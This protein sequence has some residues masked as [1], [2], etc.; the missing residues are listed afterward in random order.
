MV[1]VARRQQVLKELERIG[2]E[3]SRIS[4]PK[5]AP[6]LNVPE[7]VTALIKKYKF[8]SHLVSTIHETFR[9]VPDNQP[10]RPEVAIRL[11]NLRDALTLAQEETDINKVFET[12]YSIR[13]ELLAW[14][15]A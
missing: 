13:L 14:R 3:F 1:A 5:A 11:A 4:R 7:D 12:V 10:E 2:D 6:V 15:E 9:K 8:P